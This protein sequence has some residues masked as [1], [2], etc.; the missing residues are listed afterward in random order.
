MFFTSRTAVWSSLNPDVLLN[1][2]RTRP[3]AKQRFQ[4]YVYDDAIAKVK[5]NKLRRRHTKEW[6][7]RLEALP[8]LVSRR[9]KSDI[10]H[11]KRSAATV[12]RD[13]AVLPAALA[14][15]L[16][17]GAPNS[18]AAWQEALKAIPNA[19]GRRTLYLDR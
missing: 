19:N 9:K 18:E 13:M 4:R 7:E 8:A 16:S 6:R 12:K 17:P 14:K 15:V 5:L 3:E 1:Y 2:A 11:R 10:V